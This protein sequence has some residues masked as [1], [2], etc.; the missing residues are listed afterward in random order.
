MTEHRPFIGAYWSARRESKGECA[1]R[2]SS[3]F[4][5]LATDPLL[6]EWYAT[7]LTRR[8]SRKHIGASV[9]EI[10]SNLTE[11]RRDSDG[12]PIAELGFGMNL[13]N[14]NDAAPATMSIKCGSFAAYVQNSIALRLP[15]ESGDL[16]HMRTLLGYVVDFAE[17]DIAVATSLELMGESG[18]PWE[19]PCWF[20]YCREHGAIK[21]SDGAPDCSSASYQ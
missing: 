21:Q 2:I 19:S 11:N 4:R 14:G 20:F 15:R 3:L 13:W 9:E 1:H 5:A 12:T 18:M 16:N 10:H 7:A 8:S 6:S 17:P